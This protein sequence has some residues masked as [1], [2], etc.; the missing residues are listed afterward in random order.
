MEDPGL[1][2]IPLE[3]ETSPTQAFNTNGNVPPDPGS[4]M[5]QKAAPAPLVPAPAAPRPSTEKE[6]E[7]HVLI[8]DDNN[9]NLKVPPPPF[10]LYSL[11]TDCL[12]T[13]PVDLLAQNGLQ[14]RNG[15][16]WADC[17]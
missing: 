8:V 3:T 14:L 10:S 2:V 13:G 4:P 16:K 15:F 5:P 7:I 11:Y 9:I 6:N 12:C 1:S 17:L